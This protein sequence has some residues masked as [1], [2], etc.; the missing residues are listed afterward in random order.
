MLI[1]LCI[2]ISALFWIT[3]DHKKLLSL[4]Y[5]YILILWYVYKIPNLSPTRANIFQILPVPVPVPKWWEKALGNFRI[6]TS[7]NVK[8]F[9]CLLSRIFCRLA[10]TERHTHKHKLRIQLN[11]HYILLT[12]TLLQSTLHI[13]NS[14]ISNSAKL[15]ASLWIND[16]FWL[17]SQTIIWR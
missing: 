2:C 15:D 6:L 3:L 7:A 8:L 9:K 4:L 11:L 13:S 14:D 16:T 17:L 1:K 5:L 12:Q 10:A